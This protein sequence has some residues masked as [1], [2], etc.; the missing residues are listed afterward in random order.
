MNMAI[1]MYHVPQSWFSRL[2]SV[3]NLVWN[4]EGT[5]MAISTKAVPQCRKLTSNQQV[6]MCGQQRRCMWNRPC[7]VNFNRWT[8]HFY[9]TNHTRQQ[10]SYSTI[11][12]PPLTHWQWG[13]TRLSRQQVYNFLPLVDHSYIWPAHINNNS[14]I[15][16]VCLQL[17]YFSTSPND[18]RG[19]AF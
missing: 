11:R 18:T 4:W 19:H 13:T 6:S 2:K 3:L 14:K 9:S 15:L 10:T 5:N 8:N 1:S 12:L 17:A 7:P 16:L